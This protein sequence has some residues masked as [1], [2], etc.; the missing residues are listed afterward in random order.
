MTIAPGTNLNG[1]KL[2]W[3]LLGVCAGCGG[4]SADAAEASLGPIDAVVD[5]AAR[6]QWPGEEDADG[7]RRV[8]R[9][10]AFFDGEIVSYWYGGLAT[11]ATADVFWF[12]RPN[13]QGCPLDDHGVLDPAAAVGDPVFSRIPG[14]HGYSPYWLV[15]VVDVDLDYE[16]NAIKSALGIEEA[17]EAGKAQVRP[18]IFD[19]AG[20][21]GPAGAV[22][23]CLLVLEGTELEGNGEELVGQP[24]VLSRLV[25]RRHGWHKRY[26][27][28]YFDFTETEG[29]IPPD[30][31]S[32]SRPQM[33]ASDMYMLQ[34]DCG[35]GS[36]SPIC[37]G[38]V[39]LQPVSEPLLG[40]DIN[41]DGDAVDSNNLLAGFPGAPSEAGE[42]PYTA[43][44]RLASAT[45]QPNHDAKVVLLDSGS[46]SQLTSTAEMR[47]L[48]ELGWLSE[49]VVVTPPPGGPSVDELLFNGAVQLPAPVD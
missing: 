33:P 5:P 12:C 38:A 30:D 8:P 18:L 46:A 41:S 43:L 27:L 22:M 25:Q 7:M 6:S 14:E 35:A 10:S 17:V 3:L 34:R 39:G 13:A 47:S 19:H 31:A 37:S 21:V 2:L 9:W 44:W 4:P 16:P 20:E 29:I 23:N 36:G 40:V 26:Q 15:W 32:E 42:R 11:R 1:R 28:S 24:G 49:P 45:V 48:V